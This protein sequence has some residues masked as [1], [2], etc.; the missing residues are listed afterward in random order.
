M[1]NANGRS[2]FFWGCQRAFA[3]SVSRIPEEA[4]TALER[5]LCFSD[6]TVPRKVLGSGRWVLVEGLQV[7]G[8]SCYGA[9][10]G[11]FASGVNAWREPRTNAAPCAWPVP[12]HGDRP[13]HFCSRRVP[14]V[15]P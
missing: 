3:A 12:R 9:S 10:E 4:E 11:W 5:Q 2:R 1:A 8:E 15:V 14:S 6:Y 13:R 7:A